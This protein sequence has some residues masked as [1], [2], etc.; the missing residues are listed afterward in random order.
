MQSPQAAHMSSQY[1]LPPSL[2]ILLLC[3][4]TPADRSNE[5]ILSFLFYLK[6]K[7]SRQSGEIIV[8]HVDLHQ[9]QQQQQHDPLLL[10]QPSSTSSTSSN[11]S[12][13]D[14][15]YD[16]GEHHFLFSLIIPSSSAPSSEKSPRGRVNW[17]VSASAS[18]NSFGDCMNAGGGGGLTRSMRLK[19]KA[20]SVECAV[21]VFLVINPAPYVVPL[22]SSRQ[23]QEEE[24]ILT[25]P[26]TVVAFTC[27]YNNRIGD[28]SKLNVDVP[29]FKNEV[30]VSF[31][32]LS[33]ALSYVPLSVQFLSLLSLSSFFVKSVPIS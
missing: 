18:I 29:G 19:N 25:Y 6:T 14:N 13:I 22:S 17:H 3:T 8:S 4:R 1:L 15:I 12:D 28:T 26:C 7:S 16:Q 20:K 33:L 11:N 32:F 24:F 2:I 23:E 27:V 10:L 21:P 31:S 30:G 5:C 9:Q